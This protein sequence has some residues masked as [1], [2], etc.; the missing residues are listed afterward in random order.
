MQKYIKYSTVLIVIVLLNLIFV[1]GA[2]GAEA[3]SD[4]DVKIVKDKSFFDK[5]VNKV[6]G[7]YTIDEET[8]EKHV[9]FVYYVNE[10]GLMVGDFY[11]NTNLFDNQTKIISASMYSPTKE[12]FT[13][14]TNVAGYP[15]TDRW[16]LGGDLKIIKYNEIQNSALGNDSSDEE[17][18]ESTLDAIDAFK[19]LDRTSQAKV[20]DA[21]EKEDPSGLTEQ[22]EIDVFK[23]L[24]HE[25]QTN[26]DKMDGYRL[27]HGWNNS[28]T[29]DLTY[30]VN[31]TNDIVTAY[32]YEELE[33]QVK[34]YKS[35]T[36]SVAWE[37]KNVDRKNNPRCGHKLITKVEKS[38]DW[39]GHDSENNWD[40]TKYTLDARKY[41]PVFEESTLALRFRTQS[42]TG[43]EVVDQERTFLRQLQTGDPNVEVT[44]YAP[45]FDMALLGDLDTMKGYNYY[46]F[47]DNNSVLYQTELRFP[48]DYISPRLQGNIFAEAGRVSSDF[49]EELFTEDM[50]YSGGFGFRYFFNRDVVVR[51]DVGFSEEGTKMRMN[52]GQ[53]F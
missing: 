27:Y 34:D 8:E 17:I 23:S 48:M 3:N 33:S 22:E 49:D 51:G 4:S 29:I 36:V 37:N 1:G 30:K 5:I 52:I 45:F 20:E 42:T 11:Y 50:H 53:T 12:T 19:D 46:R 9:P 14:F 44:T 31:E 10:A 2:Y 26:G 7:Y 47:Y 35:D 32:T 15:L 43:E 16:S 21:L 40:Y 28:I 41:L 13:S 24:S 6:K 18:P 39:L 38:L 25:A